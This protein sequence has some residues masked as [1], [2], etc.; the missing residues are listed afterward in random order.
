MAF[1]GQ[2]AYAH[3]GEPELAEVA[4]RT[5][6]DGIAIAQPHRAGIPRLSHE[7]LL[8]GAALFGGARRGSDDLFQFRPALREASHGGGTLSVLHDLGSLCHG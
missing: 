6:I 2:L 5:P 3:S 8:S 7:G 1:V 4:P